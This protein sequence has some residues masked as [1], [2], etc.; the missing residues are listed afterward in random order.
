VIEE[1][2]I[3]INHFSIQPAMYTVYAISSK[4][5]NYIYIGMTADLEARLK[6]HNSG[7]EGTT[8]PEKRILPQ[9][10]LDVTCNINI[11]YF[12]HIFLIISYER[13]II[14]MVGTGT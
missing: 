5:R 10:T 9:V 6:R 1:G 8:R 11:K 4:I 14:F 3:I 12:F 13:E 2:I 7:Y